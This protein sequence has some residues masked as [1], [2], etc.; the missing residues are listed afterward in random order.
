MSSNPQSSL[1]VRPLHELTKERYLNYAMSVIMSRALPDVRDGLKPVQRRVLYAMYSDLKLYPDKKHRK[2]ATIVGA[3]MGRYHP[4]SDTALYESMV[5]M[6]QDWV[7]RV[8]LV[9]GHGNFGNI[10]GD[11]A[12]A[13]RYTE[14]RLRTAGEDMMAEIRRDVVNFRP[15]FDAT[16]HEPEVL[17]TQV[18]TLLINGASGIAV[19]MATNIPPHNPVEILNASLD[20][21]KNP[22]R[23]V[24]TLVDKHVKGPDFPTGGSIVESQ[25]AITKIY[26]T[27]RGSVT[28][29]AKWEVEKKGRKSYLIV[30]EIPYGVQKQD[31]VEKI[32][33]HIVDNSIPQ[34]VDIRDESTSDIRI[35]MELK[36]G[37]EVDNVMAYLFKHTPLESKFHVN[38]TCLAPSG[39]D[40]TK[41]EPK[42]L[43][44]KTMLQHFLD[45]RLDIV[46]RRTTFDLGKLEERIHTLEGFVTVLS[47]PQKAIDIVTKAG[48]KSE[49]RDGLIAEFGIDEDQ[50]EKV[51][52]T[53]VY[54]FAGYE[55]K[56]F[57]E[58]LAEKSSE[59]AEL[60]ALLADPDEQVKVVAK[61]L[62]EMRKRYDSARMT[63]VE[64]ALPEFEYDASAFIEKV[65][66]KI[67]VSRKGWVRRQKSY[68]DVSALRVRDGDE[69]GWVI[70][71]N[72]KETV[73]FF[74]SLG[75]VYTMRVDDLPDTT[76]YGDAIQATFSFEDGE[77]IQHVM[78]FDSEAPARDTTLLVVTDAGNGLRVDP[79]TFS[80]PSTVNGRRIIRLDEGQSVAGY[81]MVTD[82]DEDHVVL[83]TRQGFA[84]TFK[85]SLVKEVKGSGK[86]VRCIV[87]RDK[88]RDSVIAVG[89][90]SGTQGGGVT[91]VTSKGSEESYRHTSL[92]PTR[93][94]TVG[95]QV[96]S[97][98]HFVEFKK[99]VVER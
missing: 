70:A 39:S 78:T 7:L 23:K 51:L 74:T 85:S 33:S 20:L 19:G 46:R 55:V 87:L 25:D 30:T 95:E 64:V 76:G 28:V 69:I 5:R 43:D 83:V 13:H 11:N 34:I 84:T 3:T 32:A 1:S 53:K 22:S 61:E 59:A 58:E 16:A 54:R 48:S 44:L 9:D 79:N 18:P 35:V 27:G 91:V 37:A 12:A 77:T 93:R 50:A 29:R 41:I 10:D 14:A 90:S 8:P 68:T 60:R 80:E 71:S 88:K 56:A 45:F 98:V 52:N 73:A 65:P 75:Q 82:P 6:A 4:H 86:G 17:P 15:N 24:S 94:G 2:S 81:S 67:V 49:A 96:K 40:P 38:L 57:E 97:R 47:D 31:L 92:T 72:T 89:V 42:R 36:T 63:V 21:L 99:E 62:R 26:E 66:A